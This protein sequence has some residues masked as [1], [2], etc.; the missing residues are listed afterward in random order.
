MTRLASIG[1]LLLMGCSHSQD[2]R[3]DSPA[4]KPTSS[5]LSTTSPLATL[6]SVSSYFGIYDADT[7]VDYLADPFYGH[8][9][10]QA[11]MVDSDTSHDDATRLARVFPLRHRLPGL[12]SAGRTRYVTLDSVPKAMGDMFV[13]TFAAHLEPE[14][15]K[16]GPILFWTGSD[17]PREAR[18]VS[19][20]L[21]PSLTETIG[22]AADS[23][24]RIALKER[25]RARGTSTITLRN[26]HVLSVAGADSIL[27]ARADADIG[28]GGE[29]VDDRGSVF[30]VFDRVFHAIRY[31]RFGHP[32][33]SPEAP[34]VRDIRPLLF[35]T[36]RGDARVYAFAA[37]AGP[38][39]DNSF[40]ILDLATGKPVAH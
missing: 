24:F 39:E 4:T 13:G 28:V 25:P 14:A 38:W 22:H 23:L 6:D 34:S 35:F 16:T 21:T 8:L 12:D 29:S 19:V 31:G 9:T 37:Y 2:E 18:A 20:S 7:R 1:L 30:V 15:D 11:W 32:E 33:W 26:L 3:P 40:S 10:H 36:F 5:P 27:V 17:G